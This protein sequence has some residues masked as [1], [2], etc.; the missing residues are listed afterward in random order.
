ML[1]MTWRILTP[2]GWNLDEFSAQ[3]DTVISIDFARPPVPQRARIRNQGALMGRFQSL[4]RD[5]SCTHPAIVELRRRL[6]DFYTSTADYPAFQV[7][8]TRDGLYDLAVNLLK[9]SNPARPLYHILELGAGRTGFPEFCS[10]QGIQAAIDAQDVT[11]VNEEYLRPQ[12]RT[13]F[14][15]DISSIPNSGQYD[16]VIST[17]VFEHV[18]SPSEFLDQVSRLLMPGG[19]HV[20]FCPRYDLPGY[21]CPSLRHLNYVERLW[22][23]LRL[24]SSRIVARLDRIPRFWVNTDPS[25]LHTQW[26]R[27]ADAVHLVSRFDVEQWHR[28][29][30]FDVKRLYPPC[31]GF[32]GRLLWRYMTLNLACRKVTRH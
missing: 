13:V 18:S 8:Q 11:S 4:V 19:W 15:G 24:F 23:S 27:D 21:V 12:C 32:R 20:I 14:I 1:A 30:G 29:R 5:P 10:R 3:C 9:A 16:L 6:D 22:V 7:T 25:L 26:Y 17:F 28:A 2:I 31:K